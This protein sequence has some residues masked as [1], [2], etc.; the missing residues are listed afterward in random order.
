M[1]GGDGFW[2]KLHAPDRKFAVAQG[3]DFALSGFGGDFE[4]VGEALALDDEGVVTS[5]RYVL[6]DAFE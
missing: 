2:V 1:F 5:G 6:R 3:H 4:A